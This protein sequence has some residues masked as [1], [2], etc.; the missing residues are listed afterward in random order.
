MLPSN[1]S[2]GYM[3]PFVIVALRAASVGSSAVA[4]LCS[5]S[6]SA[7]LIRT[8]TRHSRIV[9]VTRCIQQI[10]QVSDYRAFF[11][12]GWVVKVSQTEQTVTAPTMTEPKDHRA[13]RLG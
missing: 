6:G 10:S 1:P 13:R 12:R 11:S 3:P 5:P 9:R 2:Y 8:S 4:P 7:E